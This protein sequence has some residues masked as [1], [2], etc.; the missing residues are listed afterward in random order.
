MGF[1]RRYNVMVHHGR[2]IFFLFVL[3]I[4]LSGSATSFGQEKAEISAI[5]PGVEIIALTK[6]PLRGSFPGEGLFYTLGKKLGDIQNGE[7]LKVK[8]IKKVKTLL[9]EQVW[10]EVE[11]DRTRSKPGEPPSGWVYAGDSGEKSCCF[12]T[13]K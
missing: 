1:M 11:R 8:E 5:F 12:A 6:V 3:A 13:K 4:S 9:A 7:E 10:V 2:K